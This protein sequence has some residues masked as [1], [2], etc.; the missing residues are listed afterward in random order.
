[1]T[2]FLAPYT[3][4]ADVDGSPLDAG[5]L[6]LG[7]YGK[8]PASFPVEVFWDADFEVPA[9]QPIRTRNGYPV[10]NGGPAKVYLKTAQHSIVIKNRNGAFVLVDFYN[11]GWD[12]SFVVDK[13]GKNQQELNDEFNLQGIKLEQLEL[14]IAKLVDTTIHVESYKNLVDADGFWDE[15]IRSAIN[16]GLTSG[17]MGQI[18][19]IKLPRGIIKVKDTSIFT[20]NSAVNKRG[21]LIEGDGRYSSVIYIITEGIEKWV[22]NN[23]VSNPKFD[24]AVFKDFGFT[25]DNAAF[26]NGFKIWSAGHE[27]AFVFDKVAYG[28]SLNAAVGLDTA[29]GGLNQGWHFWGTGNADQTDW[30]SPVGQ[31]NG[32]FITLENNQSVNFNIFGGTQITLGS[33]VRV[34]GSGGGEFNVY[35]AHITTMQKSGDSSKHWILDIDDGVNLAS[36]NDRYNFDGI[37]FEHRN[38]NTGLVKYN[39]D[40]GSLNCN[41]DECNSSGVYLA[42]EV[43]AVRIGAQKKVIFNGGNLNERHLY[44]LTST[45]LTYANGG[46][47]G[48]NDVMAG[49]ASSTDK[50][51]YNR[52][53]IAGV[54]R[55]YGRNVSYNGNYNYSINKVADFDL[56]ESANP[57]MGSRVL[58]VAHLKPKSAAFPSANAS[59]VEYTLELPVGSFIK[60]VYVERPAGGT[61]SYQLFVGSN[62][63]SVIYG[64]STLGTAADIHKIDV[65]N[66][67]KIVTA[68]N[69]VVRLWSGGDSLSQL[70]GG[71]AIIE[72]F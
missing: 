24:I 41:F 15:A 4:I 61:G 8:D 50:P 31:T 48:F 1:M 54:G 33:Y 49:I 68:S 65:V 18:A 71:L 69:Q 44:N 53:T 21:L 2:M 64:Q 26:G 27:K 45:N 39:G 6:Y 67:N 42:S 59:A 36:G 38:L 72:Y 10:H 23:G 13:N 47:I 66:V 20:Y 11:K 37:R 51:L 16:A 70:S 43:E 7:E 34:K 52:I 17:K 62:D 12:A 3:A 63:K 60:G 25:S 46:V 28:N 19:K 9:A 55:S 56:G 32:D 22:Y 58:K 35:G 30:Y 40:L 5:Y 14:K 29:A 57:R